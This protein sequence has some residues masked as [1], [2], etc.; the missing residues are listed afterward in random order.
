MEVRPQNSL[1]TPPRLAALA[2]HP[3]MP[4]LSKKPRL[5]C[6][7]VPKP[8][9]ILCDPMDCSTPGFPVLSGIPQ[10]CV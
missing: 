4:L 2:R 8:C 3:A 9:L 6:C 5:F 10:I 1:G 7:S